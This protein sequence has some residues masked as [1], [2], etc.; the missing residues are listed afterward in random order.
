[1]KKLAVAF[2][3]ESFLEILVCTAT[4]GVALLT[5]QKCPKA[6][7]GK[8]QDPD[9]PERPP[10]TAA[11][12]APARSQDLVGKGGRTAAGRAARSKVQ[13]QHDRS[14][15]CVRR[16]SVRVLVKRRCFSLHIFIV[17]SAESKCFFP[18]QDHT[19][20]QKNLLFARLILCCFSALQD[21][22]AQHH[23]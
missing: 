23:F 2:G 7:W 10:G 22:V 19:F 15:G 21:I 9:A 8:P 12:G 3:G 11:T 5:R 14:G 16:K 20:P 4:A 1:M 13:G 17:K 18:S 6:T